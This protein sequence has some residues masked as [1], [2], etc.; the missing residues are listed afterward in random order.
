MEL[1]L[2]V[3]LLMHQSPGH[4]TL[5]RSD[6]YPHYCDYDT[7]LLSQEA[8]QANNGRSESREACFQRVSSRY[9]PWPR[10]TRARVDN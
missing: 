7:K 4:N 3:V 5:L 10:V 2:A 1:L 8:H 9:P 6:Y